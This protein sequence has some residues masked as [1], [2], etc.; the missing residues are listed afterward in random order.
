MGFAWG[1]IYLVLTPK[2]STVGIG[3]SDWA[4]GQV[5]PIVLLAAPVIAVVDFFYEGEVRL[6]VDSLLY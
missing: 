5:V 4:F 1:I 6:L 2:L 3:S